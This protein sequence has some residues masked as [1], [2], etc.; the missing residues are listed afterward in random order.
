M[1]TKKQP[2][3]PVI[4]GSDENAY[5]MSR[6]F[7]EKYGII[8][9]VMCQQEQLVATRY[10]KILEIRKFDNLDVENVFIENIVKIAEEKQKDYEKLLLIPC[11]DGYFELAVKNRDIIGKYFCNKFIP[12]DLLQRF[13]TKDKFYQVCEEYNLPYPKTVVCEK[14]DRLNILNNLPFDFPIGVKANNSNSYDYLHSEFENK[15]KFFFVKTKEEY[16]DIVNNMNTSDYNDNLII[17]DFITGDDTY[18]RV[19][20][21]YCDNDGKVKL[22]CLGQPVIEEYK[23]S[24]IGN[25]GAILTAPAQSDYNLGIIEKVKRFL[26]DIKYVGF[27]NFDMKFDKKSGEYKLLDLNPRTGRSSFFITASGYNLAE[28]LVDNCVYRKNPDAVYASADRLWLTIPKSII[29]KYVENQEVLDRVKKLI[30]EKK[31]SYTL[32]YKKDMNLKRF[33]RMK[34]YYHRHIENYKKYFF[35]KP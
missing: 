8:P 14:K 20:T 30:K 21:C 1:D 28:F 25:Y 10:S 33:L 13:V 9:T 7:Y 26:E 11:S 18:M 32:L 27:V 24:A 3:L 12:Y 31:Y 35:R 19:L 15:K 29:Y 5:G 23:P 2:F 22:M 6:A 17:Q 4:L 16:T 34:L